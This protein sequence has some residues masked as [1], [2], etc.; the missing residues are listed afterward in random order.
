MPLPPLEK[1]P[2]APAWRSV[3]VGG[4][5]AVAV[6]AVWV[7]CQRLPSVWNALGIG[8][9]SQPFVDLYGLLASSDAYWAGID[10]FVP[11]DWDPYRRPFLYGEWWFVLGWLGIGREDNVWLG[12]LLGALVLLTSLFMA[13]P[14]GR[15]EWVYLLLLLVSPVWLLS[16][17]RANNDPVVLVLVSLGLC[18]YRSERWPQRVLG[19]VL[20]ASS[21]ALKYYPLVTLVVLLDSRNRRELGASLALYFAVL[22]TSW[23]FL[24]T[25]FKAASHYTPGPS[26]LYA[27]GAPILLRNFD[28]ES[29]V[30]W[31]IP[32][33]GLGLWALWLTW[34]QGRDRAPV[35]AGTSA[36]DEREFLC[37][38]SLL[39][40]LFFLG[41]SYAYKLIF[42][43]W[44]LPWLWRMA[45]S[46]GPERSWAR[47]ALGLLMGVA[48][49]DGWGA[50]GINVGLTRWAMPAALPALTVVLT[51]TQLLSWGLVVC[52]LRLLPVVAAPRLFRLLFGGP[53]AAGRSENGLPLT[54]A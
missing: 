23:P 39:V 14:R 43:V 29:R 42:A 52:L 38:A 27:F 37:G 11:L 31:L 19:I 49:L 22:V 40:G 36:T 9:A 45:T 5:A 4:I 1:K 53:A 26:W 28:L 51:V 7:T 18:C 35:A 16:F 15:C 25:G 20:F 33:A 46:P 6:W 50:V 48:C 2:S 41:A 54:A 3:C 32:A 24:E 17:T 10:P 21:V 12:F 47:W 44:M 34:R 8:Q 30:A 13:R